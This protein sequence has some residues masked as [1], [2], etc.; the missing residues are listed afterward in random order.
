MVLKKLSP[1]LIVTGLL[2]DQITKA[3]VIKHISIHSSLKLT[4]FLKI[5]HIRNY[6]ITF[7]WLQNII[8]NNIWIF[9]VLVISIICF[10]LYWLYRS[11]D[12]LVSLSL[13]LIISG[14]LGNFLDRL[15]LHYVV[16]F[17]DFHIKG[18]HW[19]AFNMADTFIVVG[20]FCIFLHTFFKK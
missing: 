16:D 8:P 3:F 9:L 20:T 6:G 17:I 13:I 11:K 5:V 1:L 2:I 4:P 18:Y 10:L 7:G 14:A 12:F 15:R 19:P